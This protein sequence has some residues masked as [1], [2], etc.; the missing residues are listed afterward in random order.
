MRGP[1]A[2][3]AATGGR[4]L[5]IR[6][7]DSKNERDVEWQLPDRTKRS[8]T[9][10][11]E[12]EARVFEASFATK[13]AAGNV[14]DPRAG[15]VIVTQVDGKLVEGNPEN[16]PAA[17]SGGGQL[18]AGGWRTEAVHRAGVRRSSRSATQLG[19]VA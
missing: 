12:R 14:V 17:G 1:P 5:T 6:R 10:M 8:E 16:V 2:P 19:G 11:T 7:R 15:R 3:E 18:T 4:Y 9:F 13:L